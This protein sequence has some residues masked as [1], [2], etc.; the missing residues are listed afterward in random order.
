MTMDGNKPFLNKSNQFRSLF[1]ERI[2]KHSRVAYMP[3]PKSDLLIMMV[4]DEILVTTEALRVNNSRLYRHLKPDAEPVGVVHSHLEDIE[5]WRLNKTPGQRRFP[6]V[7]HAVWDARQELRKGNNSQ[8]AAHI[9]P[10]HVLVA[11][12]N[13]HTCPFGPPEAP[14]TTYRPP[15]L[16]TGSGDVRVT[17]I[18]SG[19][20]TGG[21]IDGR[22]NSHAFGYWFTKDPN[23]AGGYQWVPEPMVYPSAASAL[24]QNDD[25][26]LDALVGHANF[27]AGVIA[28]GCPTA[29]IDIVSHNGSFV[30]N[31]S[32]GAPDTP[33]P[34]E[35]SVARS[36]YEAMSGSTPPDLVNLGFAFPTLP[37]IPPVGAPTNGPT[38]WTFKAVLDR[39]KGSKTLVIA[40]TGNQNSSVKQ[41]PAALH[42]AYPD[43]VIGVGSV[44]PKG[45]GPTWSKS[46]FS[47]FGTW[48]TCC[49][50]GEDVHSAFVTF[51]GQTEEAETSGP[52]VGTQ[53]PK[54]FHGWASWD[55]TSFAAP[56]VVAAIAKA[57]SAPAGAAALAPNGPLAGWNQVKQGKPSPTDLQMGILLGALPPS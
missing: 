39:T 12:P 6:D 46:L 31:D 2:A 52:D 4:I 26:Y 8:L 43:R 22:L 13:F 57:M 29:I 44:H 42:L 35:A 47:N 38:S 32:G 41:Y 11:A 55:G 17:V 50:H 5:I 3:L 53:T 51:S 15:S 23:A 27:V 33:I 54:D 10:N 45:S 18:D 36:L 16:G 56:K 7:A 30:E 37:D 34:T 20:V 14:G 19:F 48:V 1:T 28:Q 40:P 24:D 49:A 25:T 21:P 9:A